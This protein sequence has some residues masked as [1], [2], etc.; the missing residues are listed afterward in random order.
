MTGFDKKVLHLSNEGGSV[1]DLPRSRS[2]FL[3][4]ASWKRY[5]SFHCG[6]A[7]ELLYIMNSRSGFSAHWARIVRSEERLVSPPPTSLI[8]KGNYRIG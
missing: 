4:T 8:L 3:A 5:G 6:S 1:V 7:N 2:T